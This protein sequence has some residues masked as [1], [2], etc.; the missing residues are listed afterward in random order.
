MMRPLENLYYGLGEWNLRPDYLLTPTARGSLY[1]RF[2]DG[3][4]SFFSSRFR[5]RHAVSREDII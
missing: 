2:D 4:R 1:R 3:A 5:G